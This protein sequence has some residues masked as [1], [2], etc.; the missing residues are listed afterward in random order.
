MEPICPQE[1]KYTT[2]S[3]LFPLFLLWLRAAN[4]FLWEAVWSM[5]RTEKTRSLSL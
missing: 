1:V 4:W 5:E 2:F 3:V